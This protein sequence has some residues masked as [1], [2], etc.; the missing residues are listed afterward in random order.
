MVIQKYIV[1]LVV[2]FAAT[3]CGSPVSP[4]PTPARAP[5][6]AAPATPT[7]APATSAALLIEQLS[8]R[9]HPQTQGQFGYEP[10]FLLREASGN[11]G[12]TIQNIAVVAPNGNTD[13]AGPLCWR[14]TIRVP[15]EE[16]LD[17]FFT[18]A[19]ANYLS[20]CA[21]GSG[22]HSATPDLLVVVTF[23]DDEGHSGAVQ[24]RATVK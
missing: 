22:G 7:P 8:I 20:Y 14:E 23:I 10:R 6:T 9:V 2:V 17:T 15:P 24:S 19:G 21:P 1:V 3:A 5:G 18:D 11:S 12:A 4:T 16:V 13:N